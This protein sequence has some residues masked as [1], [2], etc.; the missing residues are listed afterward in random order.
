MFLH[1]FFTNFPVT[2]FPFSFLPFVIRV[3]FNIL[4]CDSFGC[5]SECM[6]RAKRGGMDSPGT[7]NAFVV[8]RRTLVSDDVAII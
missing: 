7:R 5:A 6:L 2:Y 8:D 1:T 3:E 4:F